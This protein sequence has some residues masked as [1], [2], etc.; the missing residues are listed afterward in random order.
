MTNQIKEKYHDEIPPPY[1]Q[2]ATNSPNLN[3]YMYRE[4]TEV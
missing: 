1:Q 4:P 3:A 2:V